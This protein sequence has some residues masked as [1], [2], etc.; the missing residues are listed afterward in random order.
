MSWTSAISF[1]IAGFIF[2]LIGKL[3]KPKHFPFVDHSSGRVQFHIGSKR[4]SRKSNNLYTNDRKISREWD[5]KGPPDL[6][7]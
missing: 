6:F 5:P 3:R 1:I 4:R 7:D 2:Y